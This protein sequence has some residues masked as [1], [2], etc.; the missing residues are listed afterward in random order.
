MLDKYITYFRNIATSH[1][2]ILHDQATESKD[3]A[4]KGK[5]GFTV[6]NADEVLRDLRTAM[7]SGVCLH[8]TLPTT[9]LNSEAHPTGI[10]EAGFIVASKAEKND[11]Q[12]QTH[13]YLEC[14]RAAL[15]IIARMQHDA[16]N[17]ACMPLVFDLSRLQIMPVG[18]LWDNRF[19][20]VV[21]FQMLERDLEEEMINYLNTDFAS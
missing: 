20:W 14:E 17:D 6:F 11:I 4:S 12:S 13:C 21:T 16:Q 1:Q 2:L 3:A 15:G 8:L 5:R 18:P 19:G 9:A 7:Q 10:K